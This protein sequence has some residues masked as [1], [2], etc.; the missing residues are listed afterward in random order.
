MDLLTPNN[1]LKTKLGEKKSNLPK[2][3]KQL[4][5]H[6]HE[7]HKNMPASDAII[8]LELMN[9]LGEGAR[10]Q[11][12]DLLCTEED[13]SFVFILYVFNFFFFL[14]RSQLISFPHPFLA[15]FVCFWCQR[16]NK[17]AEDCFKNESNILTHLKWDNIVKQ[18]CTFVTKD[19]NY[20]LME[21]GD[22]DLFQVIRSVLETLCYLH[23]FNVA[24]CDLKLENIVF[25][26]SV[27]VNAN[28]HQKHTIS[29]DKPKLID[30]GVAVAFE[31]DWKVCNEITGTACY[32]APERWQFHIFF[33]FLALRCCFT[34]RPF[35]FFFFFKKKKQYVYVS[36]EH[37]KKKDM[38]FFAGMY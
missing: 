19:H 35:F 37:S 34:S 6:C 7:W 32:L 18:K 12:K 22:I 8:S 10:C 17:F 9:K 30:F 13:A 14:K 3:Q 20:I 27:P 26:Y 5:L 21:L 16:R 24:H 23:K 2:K 15:F 36:N 38:T 4:Q 31:D 25:K 28:G 29:L 33:I 11:H 1:T